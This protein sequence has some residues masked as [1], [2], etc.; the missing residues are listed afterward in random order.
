MKYVVFPRGLS[1]IRHARFEDRSLLPVSA[2]CVVANAVREHLATLAGVPV[3]LR[4]WPPAIPEATAW[5]TLLRDARV[6]HVSG[7]LC[8]AAFVLRRVDAQV[9]AALLFGEHS[10]YRRA[11]Q[12]SRLED[13]I[14][15]RAVERI[16]PA[17]TSVCGDCTAQPAP[18]SAAFI[19]YF[20]LHVIEPVE[21]C[22]GVAL[23]REPAAVRTRGFSIEHVRAASIQV[24]AEISL[25]RLC[26]A[27]VATLRL[28]DVLEF[29]GGPAALRV[30]GHGIA[31]G[32]CGI[33][34]SRYAFEVGGKAQ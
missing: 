6:Y 15:R 25:R 22:L 2:A 12:L 5:Q 28:G 13:E 21:L 4:L 31:L 20:E 27:E 23:S 24:V 19:T 3:E 8:D 9:L 14:T 11:A 32:T 18:A 30:A 7:T 29:A 34:T 16:I 1:N 33:R 26:A 17:L 10:Q